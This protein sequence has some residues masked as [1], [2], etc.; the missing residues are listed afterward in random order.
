MRR[1][2]LFYQALLARPP[3]VGRVLWDP[4]RAQRRRRSSSLAAVCCWVGGVFCAVS[5]S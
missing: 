3:H 1:F 4:S 2:L 5:A